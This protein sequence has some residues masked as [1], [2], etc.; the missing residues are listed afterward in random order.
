MDPDAEAAAAAAAA[1]ARLAA[2]EKDNADLVENMR[3]MQLQPRA[4]KTER[5][6]IGDLK[7]QMTEVMTMLKLLQTGQSLETT[8]DDEKKILDKFKDPVVDTGLPIMTH[9]LE[10]P[11][12]IIPL[13]TQRDA[14]TLSILKPQVITTTIGTFDPDSTPDADFRGIWERILDHSKN[15]KLYEHEYLTI[16]RMVMKGSAATALDKMNKEYNGDIASILEAIQDLFIPQHNVYDDFEELNKFTRRPNE[17]MRTM[18]RRA[19]LLIYKLKPTVAPA[20][21]PDRRHTLLSQII[22]QVI[23][24]RTFRHLR[25]EELKCA[26]IGT[27]LTIEAMTNIIEFFETSEDLIPKAEIKLT[28]NVNTMRLID[29]PNLHQTE[30]DELKSHISDIQASIKSMTPAKR[31]RVEENRLQKMANRG[32]EIARA[33]RRLGNNPNYPNANKGIKRPADET[34]N[35]SQSQMVTRSQSNPSFRGSKT[36]QLSYPGNK[37]PQNRAYASQSQTPTYNRQD[38]NNTGTYNNYQKYN[39]YVP[40]YNRMGQTNAFNTNR[41]RSRSQSPGYRQTG[42]GRYPNNNNRGRGRYDNKQRSYNFRGKKHEVALHFYKCKVCAEPHQEGTSCEA[43]RAV[44]FS[45][46]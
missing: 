3:K 19:S 2:L 7:S 35:P 39:Q 11:V 37:Q 14:T 12:N 46:N 33:T 6:E 4:V 29:Q 23:D 34:P 24:K 27:S 28:Y 9:D 32:R 26:Q 36:P 17:H 21:W 22:K 45:P 43:V 40:Q 41:Y 16:L 10:K 38:S 13:G 31:P 30:I 25:S 42:R 44:T 8:T 20:A 5:Q 1:A 15:H 18:V